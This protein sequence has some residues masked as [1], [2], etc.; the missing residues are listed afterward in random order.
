MMPELQPKENHYEMN[1]AISELNALS[2]S[3]IESILPKLKDLPYLLIHISDPD[4]FHDLKDDNVLSIRDILKTI[5]GA[6]VLVAAHLDTKD[7]SRDYPV[8]PSHDEGVDYIFME[9]IERELLD[10]FGE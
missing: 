6:L 9:K 4:H 10:D 8:V 2:L 5:N 3:E 7:L 1:I